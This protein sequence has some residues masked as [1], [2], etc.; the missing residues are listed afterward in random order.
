MEGQYKVLNPLEPGPDCFVY[1]ISDTWDSNSKRVLSLLPQSHSFTRAQLERFFLHRQSL[2]HPL[3]PRV[4]DIAFR[5]ARLGMVCDY[6]PGPS[7]GQRMPDLSMGRLRTIAQYLAELLH[8]LHCRGFHAGYLTP[9]KLFLDEE[10]SVKMSLRWPGEL[11]TKTSPRLDS[12]RYCAPELMSEPDCST[13]ADVYSLGMLFY[14]LFTGKH[15]FSEH[16]PSTLK[17]KQLI[18]YPPMPRKINSM[19]Y[20]IRVYPFHWN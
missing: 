2:D 17:Q 7:L 8:F 10:G 18:A 3:L 19:I 6:L 11:I 5:G 16:D 1:L 15:P 13:K 12:I 20:R 14:F 4:T 9:S